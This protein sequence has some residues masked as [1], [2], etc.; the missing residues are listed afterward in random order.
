MMKNEE[1]KETRMPTRK[2]KWQPTIIG[3]LK[4]YFKNTKG[5]KMDIKNFFFLPI[6]GM[7]VEGNGY[8][9]GR[10]QEIHKRRCKH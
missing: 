6:K 7:R 5:V 10:H 8:N 9:I 1:K 4:M 2:N 3:V